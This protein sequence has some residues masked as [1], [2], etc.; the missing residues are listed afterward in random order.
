MGERGREGK[1]RC[2]LLEEHML[3]SIADPAQ[4]SVNGWGELAVD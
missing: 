4:P 3:R 1:E 2:H